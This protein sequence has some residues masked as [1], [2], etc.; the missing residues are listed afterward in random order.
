MGGVPLQTLMESA[1]GLLAVTAGTVA[2]VRFCRRKCALA[3]RASEA[4]LRESETRLKEIFASVQTGIVIIDPEGHRIV[5]ANPVALGAIGLPREH[6]V[7]A[8][9]HQF[10]CPADRGRCPVTDLGQTVNNSERVLLTAEGE[11]RAIMKNV[12]RIFIAGREHLLESFIDI[13]EM[14]HA[15]EVRHRAAAY[16]SLI[17]ASLDPLVTISSEG[18][19]TDVNAATEHVTG[20]TRQQLVGADFA[21]YF[22][23][24]ARAKAGYEQAFREGRVQDYELGIRHRDGH[25]TPVLYNLSVYRDEQGEVG[26]VFA[27]ARD[28]SERKRAE[29]EI[30]KLTE[31]LEQRVGERTAEL[32]RLNAQ[33]AQTVEKAED[34]NRAKSQ[35][36][37]NMSHEIRTPMNGILGMTELA[38]GTQLTLEQHEYLEMIKSSA[39]ALTVVINDILDLSKVEA[40]KLDLEPREF[41]LEEVFGPALKA[42]ALQAGHKGLELNF[43]TKPGTPETVVGDA[44]RLRQ[45]VVNLVGN[46]IK[47]TEHGEVA[48]RVACEP[49]EEGA[50][51]L[52]FS[53]Q[54]TGIG[55]PL[56]K[57]QVI[58]DAFSQADGSVTR[59]Y[60]GTGLGLTI[61]RRLVEMMGGRI[62]L[63]SVAGQGSTFHF[64]V[65]LGVGRGDGQAA[66]NPLP[67]EAQPGAPEAGRSRRPLNILLAEDNAVNQKVLSG[68]LEKHGHRV[69]IAANG[70]EALDKLSRAEFDLVLM[71]V[72]MP[73]MDG[74]EA[75]AAIRKRELDTGGH[76]PIV[77][78]TAHALK[79]DHY[80]CLAV[81]MDGYLSKPIRPDDLFR[82]IEHLGAGRAAVPEGATPLPRSKK[83]SNL[84]MS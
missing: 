38:L 63:E 17:E 75:T 42:L 68:L 57:Q 41:S 19:I 43:H 27:A 31:E 13:T 12:V 7:G 33:L 36:L 77:A 80:R 39:D 52:H 4:Q 67:A 69:E 83:D 56:E 50:A 32:V 61:S 20:L 9:C 18:K 46:A 1:A 28:I 5:E 82:Q 37:A 70:R 3:L 10:I 22:S 24:R 45:I 71:D 6:V 48:V 29:A 58:F 23:D 54:D 65:P 35:F 53:V 74:I 16:R 44:S 26:G 14:K 84:P 81:G 30:G 78:L 51:W 40:G 8:E 34:A 62:W 49:G 76:L 73:E 79:T 47:F 59:R 25:V 72:Q 15:E 11:R 55:I 60:G 2:L 64:G 66:R 21:N